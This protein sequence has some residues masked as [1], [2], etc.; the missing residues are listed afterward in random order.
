MAVV[1]GVDSSTQS[2]KV[3][4]RD[5]ETGELVRQGRAA[6]PDGTEVHPD[7]W[8]GALRSALAEAGGLA[9]VQALAVGAQQHGMVCL[10]ESGQ[11]VRPA[12]LWNDTRSAGAAADLI[13]E[14]GGREAGRRAWAEAVGTVPVASFTVT[15]LRWLADHEPDAAKRTAAVALPHDWLSWRLAGGPDVGLDAL[16]TDRGDA[17]GTGY[18]SAATEQYRRELLV[19]ALGHDAVLPRVLAPAEQGGTTPDGVL[20]GPGTGDNAA[21]ALGLGAHPGDVVVSIG[22]SGVACSVTEVPAIDPSGTVAGFADATGRFLPLIATLNAARVLDA[23]A[24][25][26][27]VDHEELSRLALSAPPGAD[28]LVLVPYLEGERTPNRPDATGAVHGLRL[29]TS[30][31]A[32]LAR[33]A[34]EGLLCGLADGIDA[35]VGAGAVVERVFLIGGGARSEAVRRIAPSV[36]GHPVLVPPPGEYVADG[37]ARQAAWTLVGG[38]EPPRW[39]RAGVQTYESDVVPRVRERYAEARDLTVARQQQ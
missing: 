28:G 8:W 18:W 11:V 19:R 37:A 21:A 30:T 15:K 4:I 26:L 12:L 23:I 36:L 7:A 32:H 35:L 29:A 20:L 9:D 5:A 16:F 13:E 24:A 22:T 14:L 6:H 1:A 2:C 25:V 38:P 3:V 39:E 10:D 27:R 33:A 31:A 34:V 17:S